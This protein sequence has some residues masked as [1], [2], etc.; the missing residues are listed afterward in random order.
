MCPFINSSTLAILCLFLRHACDN[1][2]K[3]ENICT[4]RTKSQCQPPSLTFRCKYDGLRGK[5]CIFATFATRRTVIIFLMLTE[6]CPSRSMYEL[7]WK[8]RTENNCTKIEKKGKSIDDLIKRIQLYRS[9]LHNFIMEHTYEVNSH[10]IVMHVN[11]ITLLCKQI[12]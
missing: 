3:L 5:M 8:N 10:I 6:A 9:F 2:T 1:A 4:Q 11:N 12:C 7:N